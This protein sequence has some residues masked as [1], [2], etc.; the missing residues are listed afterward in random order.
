MGQIDLEKKASEI[1]EIISVYTK[2]SFIGFFADF[3]RNNKVR[4][5]EEF[6]EKIKS[7]LRDSLYLIA[8]RLSTDEGSIHFDYN[9]ETKKD[10]I[11]VAN[12]INEIVIEWYN[13][14]YLFH[15]N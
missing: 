11:K 15:L 7:K 5:F 10:L 6:S 1:K 12:I 2:E 9:E 13:F 8:L 4:G 3:I 14:Q